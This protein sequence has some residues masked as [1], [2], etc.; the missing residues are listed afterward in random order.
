MKTYAIIVAAG[1]GDRMNSAQPK[2]YLQLQEKPILS[3]AIVAF[4]DCP[5]VHQ[6]TLVVPPHDVRFCHENII[7]KLSLKKPLD[8]IAGGQRRQDS[9]FNGI[10]SIDDNDSI[11]VIH[12]GVRPLIRSDMIS[13]VIKS[14]KMSGA[15][16]VGIPVPDTVK[17]VDADGHITKTIP[18]EQ[19]WLAQ[20]PQAFHY[21]LLR[22]A[23]EKI[24]EQGIEV[25]DDAAL[26]EL[27]GHPVTIRM[28]S[29]TNL[30]I[31]TEED[32]VLAEAILSQ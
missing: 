15:C 16:I 17:F 20:T 8:I 29:K 12:D 28:G 3:H 30:K 14:A 4:N 6:I 13:G 18:R 24:Q 31:T 26:L 27:L 23:H 25:T 11:V 2:Q 10:L 22:R 19:L 1:K 21:A 9:V 32:L 7:D 5:D